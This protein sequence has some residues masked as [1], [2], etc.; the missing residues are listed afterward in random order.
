[1]QRSEEET[2][3]TYFPKFL[4]WALTKLNPVLARGYLKLFSLVNFAVVYCIAV[5]LANVFVNNPF[6]SPLFIL[7]FTWLFT[8]GNLGYLMGFGFERKTVKIKISEKEETEEE[9]Q[10][11]PKKIALP[12]PMVGLVYLC[13]GL[14]MLLMTQLFVGFVALAFALGGT[15][16]LI[17][18]MQ[19]LEA[20][21]K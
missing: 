8:V 9:E 15:M 19:T 7:L 10:A 1:L 18:G 13:G 5:I 4:H 6:L 20:K 16:L 21:R 2:D 12:K 3:L 17:W 14:L 11:E